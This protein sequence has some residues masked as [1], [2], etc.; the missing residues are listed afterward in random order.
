M[1]RRMI[2]L[3]FAFATFGHCARAD[4]IVDF[5][6]TSLGPNGLGTIDVYVTG[7]DEVRR[8]NMSFLLTQVSGTGILEFRSSFDGGDPSNSNNQSNS[9]IDDPDYL[10]SGG[11]R[12]FQSVLQAN[13]NELVQSDFQLTQVMPTDG[14]LLAR[15]ELK[16]ILEP[17]DIPGFSGAE[18]R[19]TLIEGSARSFFDS[20]LE[21]AN[22]SFANFGTITISSM[23]SVPEPSSAIM[24]ISAICASCTLRRRRMLLS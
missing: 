5:D 18:Y 23:S 7:T 1:N 12:S 22:P 15:L 13:K 6:D 3:F 10:F 8:Y 11:S 20:S 17:A 24:L 14:K 21:P 16:H 9:E 4:L 19:I 2:M